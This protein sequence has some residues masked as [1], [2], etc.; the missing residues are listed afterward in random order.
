MRARSCSACRMARASRCRDRQGFLLFNTNASGADVSTEREATE[1]RLVELEVKFTEQQALL[2]D[3]SGVV[4]EQ[5][6][7]LTHLRAELARLKGRMGIIEE[8]EPQAASEK[9][10]HY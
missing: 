8:R 10:P 9:P 6:K 2:D 3:L 1:A 5:E 4:H 7:A